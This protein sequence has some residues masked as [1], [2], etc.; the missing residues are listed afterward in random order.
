[1][2]AAYGAA[3]HS[4]YQQAAAVSAV[5]GGAVVLARLAATFAALPAWLKLALFLVPVRLAANAIHTWRQRARALEAEQEV[6]ARL[7]VAKERSRI[8]RDLHDVV[9][10]NVSVMVVQAGAARMVLPDDPQRAQEVLHAVE[11]GGRTALTELRHVMGLLAM[12]GETLEEAELSPQPGLDRLGALAT[13]IRASGVPVEPAVTGGPTTL[14]PGL[15]L[16]AYRVVQEAVTNTIKHAEGASVSI[17]VEY[18]RE[19]LRVEVTDTGGTPT[20]TA[21]TGNGRGLSG[22]RERLALY[23]GVLEAG[24]RPTAG[25][26]VRATVPLAAP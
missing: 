14:P 10:H 11:E 25:F 17:R 2:I 3:V 4:P 8:A 24:P 16:T 1:M 6:A 26:R 13:R 5:I 7:A 15:D 19:S 9:T 21:R 18:A 23:D 20:A 12:D 22:L